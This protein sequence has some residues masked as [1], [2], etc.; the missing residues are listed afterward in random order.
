MEGRVTWKHGLSFDGKASRQFVVP[1]GTS[2]ESGGDDDGFSPMELLLVGL[3]GCTAMDVISILKKKQQDVVGL[4]V[5]ANGE[6]VNEYPKVFKHIVLEFIVTGH[7][8]DLA[9]V[10][11]AVELS[12]TKYCSAEGML[13][14]VAEIEH[15][16]T[17]CEAEPSS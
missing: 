5:V 8:V 1:V 13:G 9:A 3:A 17:I 12:S 6:R 15:K 4:E 7:A 10:Q 2:V 14:K 11:R 16:I